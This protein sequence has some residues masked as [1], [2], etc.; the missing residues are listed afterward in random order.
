MHKLRLV[1]KE[2]KTFTFTEKEIGKYACK[3][4]Y[5]SE[6]DNSREISA[7]K[8]LRGLDHI[9]KLYVGIHVYI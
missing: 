3:V 7:M 8:R 5:G 1:Q 2:T 9:T 4:V 6:N